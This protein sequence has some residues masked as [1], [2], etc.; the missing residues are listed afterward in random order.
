MK[1]S[2]HYL[3]PFW[4]ICHPFC[5]FLLQKRGLKGTNEGGKL[6]SDGRLETSQDDALLESKHGKAEKVSKL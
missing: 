3:P 4:A 2:I 1:Y 6:L 5:S